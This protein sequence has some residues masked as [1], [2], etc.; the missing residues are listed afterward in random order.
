[1]QQG[2]FDRA[3]H[4]QQDNTVTLA[5][6]DEMVAHFKRG[7]GFVRTPWSGDGACEARV[8]E[9]TTATLR[10]IPFETERGACA[11]CGKEGPVVIWAKAY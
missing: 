9:L 7:N 8:T 5:T 11:V 3:L 4:F 10:C 2:L 6:L 1:V